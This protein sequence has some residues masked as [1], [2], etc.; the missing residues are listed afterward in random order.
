MTQRKKAEVTKDPKS[1]IQRAK[2]RAQETTQESSQDLSR[3]EVESRAERKA[4]VAQL[5]SRGLMNDRLEVEDAE[6]GRYYCWV[7]ERD[8]DIGRYQELG[9]ELEYEAGEGEHETVD[10]RRRVADVVLMSTSRENLELIREVKDEMKE[11]KL[12]LGKKQYL[13]QAQGSPVPVIN[14]EGEGV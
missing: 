5:L 7:R 8:E 1:Q 4:R 13:E 3:E 9:F 6:E 10:N 12:K 11:K 2:E 14:P